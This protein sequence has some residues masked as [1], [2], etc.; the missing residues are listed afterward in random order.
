MARIEHVAL[1][2]KHLDKM[3]DFY[4]KYFNV[5]AGEKYTNLKKSYSSY[6]I[7]FSDG[8]RLELMHRPDILDLP[9]EE[10]AYGGWAHI[11]ISLGSKEKVLDLTEKLRKDGFTVKGEPR[12]TGD[13]YFESVILDPENNPIELTI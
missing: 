1:W 9:S 10:A 12:Y 3:R 13:G 2:V 5:Y 7:S 4:L 8:C 11:A 6:F